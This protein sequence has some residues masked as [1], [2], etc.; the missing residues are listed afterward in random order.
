LTLN[1]KPDQGTGLIRMTRQKGHFYRPVSAAIAVVALLVLSPAASADGRKL[2]TQSDWP[3]QAIGRVNMMNGGYCTGTLVAPRTVLTAAHCLQDKRTNRRAALHRLHFVAGY[4]RGEF[5][6]HGRVVDI[7]TPGVT[8]GVS[9]GLSSAGRNP[10]NDWALLTLDHDLSD[11]VAP[12]PV[13]SLD[14][15]GLLALTKQHA[16][17]V[18]A[19]Y[20]RGQAHA[21]TVDHDCNLGKIDPVRKVLLHECTNVPGDSG[22][23]I[24]ARFNDSYA[25]IAVNIA[26][27]KSRLPGVDGFGI[28]IPGSTFGKLIGIKTTD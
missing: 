14:A 12:V 4:Q 20:R 17:F 24:L 27:A 21:L 8:P 16:G 25:L 15:A 6:A 11:T 9:S 3:W 13:L 5:L 10:G 18:Q 23:P 22:G 19:G 1:K 28:A 26:Q 7:V 2:V